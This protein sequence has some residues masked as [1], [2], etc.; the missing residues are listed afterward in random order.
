MSKE[1]EPTKL[2]KKD[3]V[4]RKK[5]AAYGM[6]PFA[7]SFIFVAYNTLVFYYYQV[8]LG[9]ATYLVGLSFV[10]YAVWNMINDPL[11]GYLTDKPNRWSKKYGLRAPWIIIAGIFQAVL[12]F[13]MFFIPFDVSDVNSNPW[14]L[15][16]Y[17]VIITCLWDTAFSLFTTH[18]IG[19][20]ANI[21]RTPDQRRK[22]STMMLIVGIFGR[23][24]AIGVVVPLMIVLGDPS[25]YVRTALVC[26]IVLLISLIIFI[27]GVYENEFVKKRYLQI[28]EFLETQKLPYF[29][30]IKIAFKQKNWVVWL[31]VYGFYVI[32]M[33]LGQASSIYFIVEVLDLPLSVFVLTTAVWMMGFIPC[34]FLWSWVAK[35]TAHSNLTTMALFIFVCLSMITFLF[36]VDLTGLLIVNFLSGIG[37][38]AWLCIIFSITADCND[39]VTN[40]AGRH[41]EATLV[42]IKSFFFRVAYLV[43]GVIIAGVQI[44]TGYQPGASEQTELAKLGI[45]IHNNLI[46]A[47]FMVAAALVMLKFYDLKGEK[48]IAQMA[49]LR[50]QGL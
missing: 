15:F 22:A 47:L 3:V 45:R 26:T 9:L 38:A 34:I 5:M 50:K 1:S 18:Y 12:W 16:W 11:V 23:T 10:I 37:G 46:P 29:K 20:F 44:A 48:K 19:G 36:V 24:F 27:P 33:M 31:L 6:G 41:M 14:P 32:G 42:G 39:E 49:S 2:F 17:M 28:Y 4:S 30:T 13:F 43:I 35:K 7:N 40:A 25:S 8:E 21:F